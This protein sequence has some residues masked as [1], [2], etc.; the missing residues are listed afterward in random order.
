MLEEQETQAAGWGCHRY[1]QNPPLLALP[2]QI[3]PVADII[4]RAAPGGA[5]YHITLNGSEGQDAH[6]SGLDRRPG[7]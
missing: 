2:F 4:D 7:P 5:S 1:S 6:L 3:I